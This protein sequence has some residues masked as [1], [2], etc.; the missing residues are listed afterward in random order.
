MQNVSRDVK[1]KHYLM[2]CELHYPDLHG[3]NESSDP[4]IENHY[5]VFE[6]FDPITGIV[7]NDTDEY[8]EYDTDTEYNSD[9][10]SEYEENRLDRIDDKIKLLK[11]V[12]TNNLRHASP[13]YFGP[14]PT[15][16]NYRNIVLNPNYIKPEIGEYIILPTQEA[17]AILK[18]FWLRIIQKKWKKV[19][20]ERKNVIRQRCNL[21]NLSIREI[22]GRWHE[23]CFN[24]PG[25]RGM[26]SDLK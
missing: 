3:K 14:H 23:S 11:H 21:S 16:R 13:Q 4:N 18:T 26:L 12:Y 24:L 25:L 6:R 22:R 9:S 20:Q 15:I 19:F 17:I 1:N 7:L 10:D 8:N 5:L 2:L